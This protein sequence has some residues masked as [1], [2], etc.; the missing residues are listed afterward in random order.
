[1]TTANLDRLRRAADAR[2]LEFSKRLKLT[3]KRTRPNRLADDALRYFDPEFKGLRRFEMAVRQHP[4]VAL[5]TLFGLSWLASRALI[6][7]RS[8]DPSQLRRSRRL[9]TFSPRQTTGDRYNG[10][11][12]NKRDQ[13]RADT[14]EAAGIAPGG[15]QAA[16]HGGEPAGS[17]G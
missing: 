4:A 6:H 11:E 15:A 16:E 12:H 13:N 3:H 14:E 10:H 9:L 7:G 17:S 5:A 1:M 2:K 8:P